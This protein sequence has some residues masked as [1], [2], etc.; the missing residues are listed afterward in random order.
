MLDW[1][2]TLRILSMDREP[3]DEDKIKGDLEGLKIWKW[4]KTKLPPFATHMALM[5]E[6]YANASLTE[7]TFGSHSPN[8]WTEI[9]YEDADAN[10]IMLHLGN[11]LG[12]KPLLPEE[13][14]KKMNCFVAVEAKRVEDNSTT[15]TSIAPDG[16]KVQ[17]TYKNLSDLRALKSWEHDLEEFAFLWM[18]GRLPQQKKKAKKKDS[19]LLTAS[20]FFGE[21]EEK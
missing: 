5:T 9:E 13:Y 21:D 10:N 15:F 11:V 7:A 6:I 17:A 3:T 2:I 12:K 18:Y 4:K 8:T 14:A 16:L 19:E 20:G 1:K